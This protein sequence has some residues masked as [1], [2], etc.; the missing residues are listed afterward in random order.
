MLQ[1]GGSQNGNATP[2]APDHFVDGGSLG[3]QMA[4]GD[5]SMFGFGTVTHMEG[6]RL[7]GFGHPMMNAGDTAIPAAIARVMWIY[8]SEQ[9]SFKVGEAARTLGA[10]VNDRQSAV[11]IDETKRAP[12]FPVHLEVKGV[13]GAPKTT[14]NVDLAEEKFMSPALSAAVL[15]SALEATVS[16]RRDL[17]W[18]M[19]S[20]LTIRGH[21]PIELDDFGVAIGGMPDTGEWLSSRAVRTLGDAL[22]NP[23]E[24]IHVDGLQSTLELKYERDVLRLRGIDVLDPIVDAGEKARFVLHLRPFSGAEITRAVEIAIPAELAGRDVEVEIVPGY[25]IAPDVAPPENLDQLLANATHGSLR[26]LSIVLQIKMPTQ[27]VAFFGHV[28]PRL[29]SFALDALRPTTSDVAPEVIAS[30]VRAIVPIDRYVEGR[31]KAKIK[32]RAK[33]R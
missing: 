25:E 9:H 13:T 30:Y 1:A 16:D 12:T 14:W 29:P 23:W 20:R 5:V 2:G 17:T 11:I 32:V 7:C 19:K 31:D 15:S 21:A 24:E 6:T 4:R 10:L 27:G 28:S 26:P 18:T 22:S 33:L 3:I 8:A